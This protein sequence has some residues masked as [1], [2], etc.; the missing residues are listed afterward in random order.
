MTAPG[1]T[2]DEA[3]KVAELLRQIVAGSPFTLGAHKRII[4][5]S[6]GVAV[7]TGADDTA[8]SII[9]AADNAL[10]AAKTAGRN[11]VVLA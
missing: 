5:A 2:R 11:Q 1:A 8:E 4:T 6:F 7:S 3:R 10:Y 9:A